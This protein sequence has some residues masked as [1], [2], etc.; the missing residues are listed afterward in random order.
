MVHDLL[1]VTQGRKKRQ[2]PTQTVTGIDPFASPTK[3]GTE[4]G[5][6]PA[7]GVGGDNT[8]LLSLLTLSQGQ[9]ASTAAAIAEASTAAAPGISAVEGDSNTGSTAAAGSGI[10]SQPGAAQTE[11]QP[12]A[13][14][15]TTVRIQT[16]VLKTVDVTAEATAPATDIAPQGAAPSAGGDGQER[17]QQPSAAVTVVFVTAEPTFTGPTAGFTTLSPDTS[18]R[19]ATTVPSAATGSQPEP[20]AA[21]SAPEV[22]STTAVASTATQDVA[23]TS[24]SDVE[25][26][27]PTRAATTAATSPTKTDGAVVVPVTPSPLQGQITVTETVTMTVTSR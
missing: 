25:N 26:T 6:V 13:T 27:V 8:S 5:K 21:G 24:E 9:S 20:N 18:G 10:G 11:V 14:S 23:S 19:V 3:K 1:T 15:T 12:L 22:L 2:A 7:V 17:G 16:T 4:D